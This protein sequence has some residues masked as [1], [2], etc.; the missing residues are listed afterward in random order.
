[1]K[2]K[3]LTILLATF[4][5]L[6]FSFGMKITAQAETPLYRLYQ[7]DLKVHL[8]TKDTN[9]YNVLATRGW[10]QEGVAWSTEENQGDIVYRLYNPS[11]KVHLYTKDTYE[12]AVLATRGWK[13]EGEAF[14]SFGATPV[15]RLYNPGLK[16]HLYTKGKYEYDVLGTRGWVQEGVAFYAA[17]APTPP[18]ATDGFVVTIEYKTTDGTA[19]FDSETG[20][21]LVY[22]TTVRYGGVADLG[23]PEGYQVKKVFLWTG[24]AGEGD[25]QPVVKDWNVSTLVQHPHSLSY[26][27]LT[28]LQEQTGARRFY[29]EVSLEKTAN[30]EN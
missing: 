18:P 11:L 25:S 28:K 9:E 2:Q 15:Y 30:P 12:Y 16:K 7:P 17:D 8:Y 20:T 5:T 23:L 4:V 19:P 22:T 1:M 24:A 26:D 13:Q 14:R 21:N 3:Q 6:L 10:N 27:Q 29:L